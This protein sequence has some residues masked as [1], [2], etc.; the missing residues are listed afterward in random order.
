MQN[1]RN[2][3]MTVGDITPHLIK[4]TIPL[5]VGNLFQLTYSAV[6]SII[7][8]RYLG[9][10][11]FA[12]V[13][14][15]APIINIVMFLIVG[16]CLG[17]SILM[18]EIYG[19]GDIS[20]L[21]REISTSFIAGSWFTLLMVL[22]GIIFAP[23]ILQLLNT[24]DAILP[25]SALYLRYIFGGLIFSFVYNIY[26][27]T[28][29]SMGN[30]KVPLN[31]LML[32][33]ILN[34]VMD[35]L[36][37][38]VFQLGIR[39]VALATVLAEAISALL[40]VIYVRVYI[41]QLK[42]QKS[43]FKI[44][45]TLLRS[46]ISYSTVAAMQ[47]SANYIGKML[48][49]GQVNLLGVHSI[50]AFNAVNKMDDFVMIPQ[51]NIGHADSTFL[52]QNKGAKAWQ[53]MA[54]GFVIAVRMEMVYSAIITISIF[55][56]SR[57]IMELFVGSDETEIVN[58]GVTYLHWMALFYFIPGFTNIIQGFFRGIGRM[59]ITLNSTLVS[60]SGRVL[61][62]YV[63]APVWGMKGLAIACLLGWLGMFAYE[64]PIFRK[65]WKRL[66]S[67]YE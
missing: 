26:A 39:G 25:S 47:Q 62:V 22:V 59:K 56:F 13:G 51:Q 41:P 9:A 18:S 34:V 14:V 49:Q 46:T 58:L 64:L 48:I 11:A 45:R 23:Q 27:A 15:V 53:R 38:I 36:F 32:S 40:C 57:Q 3:N 65:E 35:V 10:E 28:L 61:W 8:G 29:R 19:S 5:V 52:A 12:A 20:K 67:K 31:F 54:R 4:F 24:P 6:D 7:V 37:I 17:M 63:L 42:I 30:S 60:I 50:A 21:R 44:D 33:A 66:L 55:A 16:I 2:G 43:E 1:L